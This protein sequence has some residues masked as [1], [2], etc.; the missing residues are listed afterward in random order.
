MATITVF[1]AASLP[2]DPGEGFVASATS[3]RLTLQYPATNYAE[4]YIGTGFAY[5]SDGTPISGVVT[6]VELA[7]AGRVAL[8]FADLAIRV[9]VVVDAILNNDAAALVRLLFGGNDLFW[10]SN[11]AE[12][13]NGLDGGDTMIALDGDDVVHGGLGADDVNGNIG[14]DNVFGDEG[15]DIVRGGRGADTLDG[16]AGDDPHVNGN[17]GDDLVRGGSGNDTVY[18]GQGQDTLRGEVGL[19]LLSGD[20]G[21]DVLFGGSGADRFA[22]RAGGGA[23]RVAD[24]NAAEG[25]RLLLSPGAS[26]SFVTLNGYAGVRLSGGETLEF[27]GIAPSSATAD[28]IVFG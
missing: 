28:W 27:T 5:A 11:G 13:I 7:V 26:Y 24:F 15:A 8:T 4:I 6:G 10:G 17:I 3:S 23:D 9:P 25:D 12:E 16:G 1:D 2:A 18:G 20:L 19:D 22:L 21:D 14:Q